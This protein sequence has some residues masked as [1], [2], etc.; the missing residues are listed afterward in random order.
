MT[1]GDL[2][3]HVK[4]DMERDSPFSYA[5]HAC[6]RCCRNKAIRVSPYDILRL[7][8]YLC[9]STTQFIE[10]TRRPAALSYGR[11]KTAIAASSASA[12]AVFIRIDRWPA[13]SI[14]WRDGF[15]QMATNRSAI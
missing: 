14:R 3:S 1:Y 7:A 6:N 4:F 15:H 5:C 9:I 10:I 12:A 11:Q 13:A 2:V 8:R